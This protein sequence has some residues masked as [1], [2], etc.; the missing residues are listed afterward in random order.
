MMPILSFMYSGSYRK[1]FVVDALHHGLFVPH[2]LH[3]PNGTLPDSMNH[4]PRPRLLKVDIKLV[5]L[6]AYAVLNDY[7]LDI[8]LIA[9][10]LISR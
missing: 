10:F 8:I 1:H 7:T 4:Q 6:D 5:R 9:V 3:L 2:L